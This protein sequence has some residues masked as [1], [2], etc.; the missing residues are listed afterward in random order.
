[1]RERAV[2]LAR[3]G[4]HVFRLRGHTPFEPGWQD[5]AT[6]DPARVYSR[7]TCPVFGTEQ[8]HNIGIATG[9]RLPNGRFLT[10][11][12]VDVKAE[13]QGDKSLKMLEA[14]HDETVA[15]TYRVRTPSQGWHDYLETKK[16]IGNSASS[17]APGIDIRGFGGYVV[18]AGSVR[19]KGEYVVEREGPFA[20]APAFLL[21]EKAKPK[22]EAAPEIA[23]DTASGIARAIDYLLNGA[24]EALAGSAGNTT[25]F[26]VF[27]RLREFGVSEDTAFDLVAEHWNETK[28]SPPWSADELEILCHNAYKHA[29]NDAGSAMAENEFDAVNVRD[30]LRGGIEVE[31]INRFEAADI[32][33]RKWLLGA[34]VARQYLTGLISPPGVGKTTFLI[35]MAVAVATGRSDITGF[36]VHE[37]TRVLLWNQEDEQDELKRRLLAVMAAFDVKWEDIEIDGRPG[38]VLGS[39]VD[40]AL[41]FAKR[42][43]S[44]AL[45]QS[46]DAATLETFIKEQGI[47][48]AIFDPFV[49]LHPAN[50]NDN[51]EVA[52]VAR[53]FRR[54]AVRGE[55]GVVLAHHTRKPPSAAASDAY[56]GNMDT[57]RGAGALNGVARMV[58]TLYSMDAVTA[59]RF[60]VNE[61]DA[62]KYIRFDD[63]KSNLSLIGSEPLFFKREGV[64]IGGFGGE[65]VGVL[66]PVS[67]ARSKDAKVVARDDLVSDVIEALGDSDARPVADI[68]K[69][70]AALPMR[71]DTSPDAI[72]KAIKRTFAEPVKADNSNIYSLEERSIPGRKGRFATL[73][74]TAGQT[75][76]DTVREQE[77]GN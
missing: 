67:L 7:W 56:A 27:A 31:W 9:R 37:R 1:M 47:G 63:A 4:F 22:Q 51:T 29:Q 73:L 75:G 60:G 40:R 5:E 6:T 53:I 41:M 18:A 20:A 57:S 54:V 33:R 2:E 49:E 25:T 76:F 65:E 13:K 71:A 42:N 68:A 38:I 43:D 32:P 16:Q 21:V 58:A 77:K 39:G 10:V 66:R 24:P 11:L 46:I 19:A 59:K 48:M 50:E 14:I 45:V 64:V 8:G 30:R 69:D 52:A 28:A 15:P 55:C 26:K 3:Q 70:L 74:R 23:A 17:L 35:M 34:F 72:A 61:S 44:G 12:D 36:K 62:R